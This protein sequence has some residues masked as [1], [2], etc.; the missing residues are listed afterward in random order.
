MDAAADRLPQRSDARTECG[1]PIKN[2][3]PADVVRRGGGDVD[4]FLGEI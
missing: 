1:P 2:G 4:G 3:V